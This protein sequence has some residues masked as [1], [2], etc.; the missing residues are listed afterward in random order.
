MQA[1][2]E[3]DV[4]LQ[5]QTTHASGSD[6]IALARMSID[7]TFRGDLDAQS[8]GEMLSA[9]TTVP[10]SAGYVAI[11]QV[12]GRLNGRSGSFVLQHFGTMDHGAPR[13]VLE[14]VPD[15]ASGE[16]AGLA[17]AM[18]IRIEAGKHYYTFDYTL[19]APS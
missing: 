11:E 5:P 17:G 16:L 18:T 6:G 3:F 1:I 10:G 9:V 14:V 4:K 8:Q 13:L 19:P 7:K 2:G 12:H 15:S